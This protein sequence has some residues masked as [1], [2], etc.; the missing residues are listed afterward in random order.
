M[1]CLWE[2][3]KKE[4]ASGLKVEEEALFLKAIVFLISLLSGKIVYLSSFFSVKS[5]GTLGR[6]IGSNKDMC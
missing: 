1:V 5:V 6:I 4:T 3:G 2:R